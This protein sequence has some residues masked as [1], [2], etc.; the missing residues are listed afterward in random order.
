VNLASGTKATSS[1]VYD[2]WA[3][4]VFGVDGHFNDNHQSGSSI[5]H[6]TSNGTSSNQWWETDLESVQP[7]STIEL[8]P[9]ADGY[10]ESLQNYYVFI[11]DKPFDS[12]DPTATLAQAGVSAYYFAN[13]P[14]RHLPINR[15]GRYIRVQK[16]GTGNY[17]GFAEFR[18]WSQAK[19]LGALASPAE[20]SS[21]ESPNP[22]DFATAYKR[23]QV[24]VA[25]SSR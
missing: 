17:I 21:A 19:L 24:T 14:H 25:E 23:P 10:P 18:I 12:K 15:S 9:R 11:S 6:T 8:I 2:G 13:P 7:I 5:F 3:Y 22:F 1:S 20:V 16:P 4:P